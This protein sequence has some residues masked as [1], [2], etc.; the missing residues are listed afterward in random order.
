MSR[1]PRVH[2]CAI[3]FGNDFGKVYPNSKTVYLS[4]L[5]SMR[6]K[7]E[8][9]SLTRCM[10]SLPVRIALLCSTGR[11]FLAV[12]P[13]RLTYSVFMCSPGS[14]SFFVGDS[15]GVNTVV[16]VPGPVLKTS[17]MDPWWDR[18]VEKSKKYCQGYYLYKMFMR[19]CK[20]SLFTSVFV[21]KAVN[22]RMQ[23][24]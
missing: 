3:P 8:N 4:V 2:I 10:Y 22:Q 11:D 12:S 18:S 6:S 17:T 14:L 9:F 15:G 20:K 23:I 1:L 21:Y 24:Y 16:P 13:R 5:F 7:R 19:H